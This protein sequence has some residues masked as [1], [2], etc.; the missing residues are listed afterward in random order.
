KR[1]FTKTDGSYRIEKSIRDLC[2]FAPHNM[3][4]DPPFSRIDL[5]SCCNLMI[6]LDDVLQK[7]ILSTFHYSLNPEGLLVLGKSESIGPSTQLFSVIEK[8][9]KVFARKRDINQ[10]IV[11]DL[12]YRLHDFD[13]NPVRAISKETQ[14]EQNQGI[15]LEKMVDGILLDKYIPA[16]VVIN[17]HLEILQFRGSIG[18]FLEPSSG[19]ASLNL[20][21]MA[22]AGLSFELRNTI[23]KASKSGQPAK[24]IG[25]ELI[26]NNVLSLITIEAVPL[27]S[28]TEDKLFLVLFNQVPV[29]ELSE[30]RTT[31]SKDKLVRQLEDELKAVK[32]DMRSIIEEQ[33][34]GNEELQSANEEIVSSNEE[35]QSINEELETSKEEL[36]SANE[37]LMTINTE[38]QMRNEQLAE[39]FEYAEAVFETIREAILILDKD[40]RI[41]SANNSFYKIF[42]TTEEEIEGML[43]F[44]LANRAWD[45]PVFR[46]LLLNKLS[47]INQLHG[48]EIIH[49]FPVIG[50]KI[51]LVNACKVV[52]KIHQQQLILLAFED[53]TELRKHGG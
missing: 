45:I 4:K 20:L 50:E 42:S 11:S 37:E 46:D 44:E 24:K 34:A 21:K 6:Y 49:S 48:I 1:F 29:P 9:F 10:R 2:V 47:K 43:I 40:L 36:E 35:L 7:K 16:S 17:N 18:L 26:I 15:D 23:H 28:E 19:K 32:D 39:A 13:R 27:R 5:I 33:E 14:M 22:R 31:K 3:L 52:Q 41:K 51:L 38:L 25:I 12:N 53:I 8:K 30:I